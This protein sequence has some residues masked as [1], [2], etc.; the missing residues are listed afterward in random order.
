[1]YEKAAVS[2]KD[3]RE[4]IAKLQSENEALREKA[5]R[6]LRVA[7]SEKGAVSLYGLRRF[8]VTF[9][10]AEWEAIAQRMPEILTFINENED[11]SRK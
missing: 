3:L 5:T 8:P 6:K 4:Q 2:T 1:M 10:A 11:L 7:R 9:Y